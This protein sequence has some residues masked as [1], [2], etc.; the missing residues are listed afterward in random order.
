MEV[1]GRSARATEAAGELALWVLAALCFLY[2]YG[3]PLAGSER[4]FQNGAKAPGTLRLVTWNV[5]GSDGDGG[6]PLADEY[7]EHVADVIA[8]LD[9][10]LVLLQEVDDRRQVSALFR[11]LGWREGDAEMP[12]GGGRRVAILARDHW[13]AAER[14]S[15]YPRTTLRCRVY[16]S[17]RDR[18]RLRRSILTVADV[19]ADAWSSEERNDQVGR[20]ADELA[21]GTSGPTVLAGD[22]NLDLDIDKRRDLFSDDSY[23]DVETYNF[24]VERFQ[25][26]AQGRGSTAEPDRRLDYIFV[27]GRIEVLD[28][29]PFKDRR[30][31]DMDHDP[32]VAD[33]K[34]N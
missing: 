15:H 11:L 33:V 19:H 5:G 30:V 10:D 4:G 14:V 21:R 3:I 2:G 16:K 32:V 34:L 9:A 8:E 1:R 28:A 23:R 29:G 24:V 20:V 12:S 18:D 22:F 17:R 26:A 13:L 6:R 31:A 7:L 27:R 25:D